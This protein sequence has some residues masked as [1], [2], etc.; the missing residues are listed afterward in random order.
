[1]SRRIRSLSLAIF[2]SAVMVFT[3]IPASINN[4]VFAETPEEWAEIAGSW[5]LSHFVNGVVITDDEGTQIFPDASD[6]AQ[7]KYGEKY[8]FK[9]SFKEGIDSGQLKYDAPAPAGRLRYQLPSDLLVTEEISGDI[10]SNGISIGWYKVSTNGAVE[11][12]F[13]DFDIDGNPIDQNFIYEYTD[14]GFVLEIDTEFKKGLSTGH[15]DFGTN[16]EIEFNISVPD[17]ELEV[18]KSIPLNGYDADN[19]TVDYQ[20]VIKAKDANESS[21]EDILFSDTPRMGST[22]LHRN[23][24]SIYSGITYTVYNSDDTIKQAAKDITNDVA[25]IKPPSGTGDNNNRTR[26]EY[27][28]KG[29]N[30]GPGEYITVDYTLDLK[31]MLDPN[32]GNQSGSSRNQLNYNFALYNTV[33]AES[34]GKKV[35][36]TESQTVRKDLKI[37]KNGVRDSVENSIRWTATVGGGTNSRPLNGGT[38]TDTLSISGQTG[39]GINIEL[40]AATDIDVIWKDSNGVAIGTYKASELPGFTISNDKK[41]FTYDV[42]TADPKIH[43]I[44]F[45]YNTAFTPPTSGSTATTFKNTIKYEKDGNTISA[46]DSVVVRPPVLYDSTIVSKTGKVNGS[47]ID[48]VA[49]IGNG[50]E[51]LNGSIVNVQDLLGQ[52]MTLPADSAISIVFYR[53]P[54]GLN[55]SNNQAIFLDA[56]KI[57]T[58]TGANYPYSIDIDYG[59]NEL[60]FSVPPVGTET[61]PAPAVYRIVLSYSTSITVPGF[62]EDAITYTNFVGIGT[63]DDEKATQ[64]VT[65][66]PPTPK[67][68][69]IKKQSSHIKE[70]TSATANDPASYGIEYTVV[71]TIPEG[72]NITGYNNIF[73]RDN[74][75]ITNP[76]TGRIIDISS[77]TPADFTVA[78]APTDSST[79]GFEYSIVVA[80][81]G[82][83]NRWEIY[84]GGDDITSSSNSVWKYDD[85]RTVTVTFTIPLSEADVTH[86]M[87]GSANYIAN[88]AYIFQN[89]KNQNSTVYDSWPIFKSVKVSSDDDAVFDY[90]VTLNSSNGINAISLFT[91]GEPALFIDEFDS[92]LEYVPKS[93]YVTAGTTR[94]GPYDDSAAPGSRIDSDDVVEDSAAITVGTGTV[95]VDLAELHQLIWNSSLAASTVRS[96]VQNPSWFTSASQI[97]IR[98]QLKLTDPN[99]ADGEKFDNVASI[100]STTQETTFSNNN[101][102]T[103]EKRPLTKAL[104]G[105][106]GSNIISAEIVVN[107]HGLKLVPAEINQDW[108]NAVDEMSS[109]LSFFLDTIK[110]YTKD[111]NTGDWKTT[112]EIPVAHGDVELYSTKMINSQ[113]AEFILPDETPVKIVYNAL[114]TQNGN[115]SNSISVYGYSAFD[116]RDNYKVIDTKASVSAGREPV[117]LY[118][119]DSVDN[120][121]LLPGAS[122]ELYMAVSSN[123]YYIPSG[124][125]T[126]KITFDG[127]DFYQIPEGSVTSGADGTALFNSEWITH[128]HGAIYMIVETAAPSGYILPEVPDNYSFF[129]LPGIPTKYSDINFL[130]DFEEK[131]H[132]KYEDYSPLVITDH[133]NVYNDAVDIIPAI[134]IEVR[135]D[136][137]KRTAAAFDGQDANVKVDGQIINN[138]GVEKEHYRYD[139]DFRSTSNVDADEFVVIDPLEAVRDGL[140]RVEGFWTPATWGDMDGRMNVWYKSTK[141]PVPGKSPVPPT[142]AV[143]TLPPGQQ[144]V[145]PITGADGWKLWTTINDPGFS[146]TGII[147]RQILGL[148]VDL[149]DGDYITA[150]ALE[151]GAVKVGFTSKNYGDEVG[152]GT[153]AQP[154]N[155]GLD[156]KDNGIRNTNGSLGYYNKSGLGGIVEIDSTDTRTSPL[157]ST[158]IEPA[159]F[160]LGFSQF[161]TM[162]AA[163]NDFALMSD[164]IAALDAGDIPVPAKGTTN[165]WAPVLDRR[166][167]S[168]ELALL[169]TTMASSPLEPATYLVSALAPMQTTD[170]VS[171]IGAFIA[172]GGNGPTGLYDNDQDAVLTRE[173]VTFT[174]NPAPDPDVG[175][176]VDGGSFLE[177]AKNVGITLKDGIWYD[178][179]GRRVSVRTGDVF[180]LD[181]LTLITIV[182]LACIVLLLVTYFRT[183]STSP[184][185]R[186][187]KQTD[188]EAP[189]KGGH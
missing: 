28:F 23:T 26:M 48:W 99:T 82:N 73:I 101:T 104:K 162:M 140:I 148:P 17:P 181:F 141:P 156:G 69:T 168:P 77:L 110:F 151:Y 180:M 68:P 175:R 62:G 76:A 176:I 37:Q 51:P 40:P 122:F 27:L 39:S 112:P 20:V 158:S 160:L 120:E 84:F 116:N 107:P 83:K 80:P 52:G 135:K 189:K 106:D 166:D 89:D 35:S 152:A 9:I 174:S 71:A 167:Y 171:S 169:P 64:N 25:W 124:Q 154:M 186:R 173:I 66:Y 55:T 172:R 121:L 46:E 45:S 29:I 18:D 31:K 8:T 185:A 36:D 98:Y 16:A 12:W 130:N 57:A 22:Y 63:D 187:R 163:S 161:Q 147:D 87:S 182:A 105:T 102:A 137:I 88:T 157:S 95:E 7:F 19:E 183:P 13:G 131:Y 59:D 10:K 85:A 50:A 118:K 2:L 143:T 6:I 53:A 134:S 150:I 103:Y 1:M 15:L 58:Y 123:S 117:T 93:F 96:S 4:A 79:L 42:P 21:V 81:G 170:I 75:A 119:R 100:N 86:L 78:L 14:A 144:P 138:V 11:V 108:F 133:I 114:V 164:Q 41:T 109:N 92:R 179:N 56:D 129:Y 32:S 30:L 44:D 142:P 159:S 155:K 178:K 145:Y 47:K 177:R 127:Y 113:K 146:S 5:D 115:I 72:N 24:P 43:S 65:V 74:V 153:D 188:F 60:N 54:T 165:D 139:V 136:T 38:I 111:V 126:K 149:A 3:L 91:A 125:P 90:T 70:I 49:T 97:T 34:Y 33:V 132:E 67:T 94:F 61:P 128:S 184:A